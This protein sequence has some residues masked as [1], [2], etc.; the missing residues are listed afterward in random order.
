MRIGRVKNL[1]CYS[2]SRWSRNEYEDGY[3][4]LKYFKKYHVDVYEGENGDTGIFMGGTINFGY[5]NVDKRWEIDEDE[6]RKSREVYE[7]TSSDLEKFNQFMES[8][9]KCKD[10]HQS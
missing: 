10:L 6:E 9:S 3:I 8:I 7:C 1:W 5:K 2:R 4:R